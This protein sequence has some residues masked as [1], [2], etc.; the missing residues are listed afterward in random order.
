MSFSILSLIE[1]GKP[2]DIRFTEV[3]HDYVNLEWNIPARPNGNIIKYEVRYKINCTGGSW[4]VHK[5]NIQPYARSAKV[6]ELV[7]NAYYDFEI[8]AKTVIGWGEYAREHV[9]IVTDKR[10]CLPSGDVVRGV[11]SK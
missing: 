8:R 11:I 3:S 10:K 6:Q 7:F 1:P 2:R 4:N 5:D 9:L